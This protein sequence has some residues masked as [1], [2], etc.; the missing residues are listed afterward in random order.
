MIA[1]ERWCSNVE[2]ATVSGDRDGVFVAA[3]RR[4]GNIGRKLGVV[5]KTV[6]LQAAERDDA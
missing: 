5:Y 1:A 3:R 2:R 6:A 4:P